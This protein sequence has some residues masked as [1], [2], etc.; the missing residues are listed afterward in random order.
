MCDVVIL[1]RIVLMYGPWWTIKNFW[2]EASFLWRLKF[3]LVQMVINLEILTGVS[4]WHGFVACGR[5]EKPCWLSSR[6]AFS[7]EFTHWHLVVLWATRIAD[8]H[9]VRNILTSLCCLYHADWYQWKV[10]NSEMPYSTFKLLCRLRTFLFTTLI[11]NT[12]NYWL[13]HFQRI[14]CSLSAA[15]E[16]SGRTGWKKRSLIALVF[17]PSPYEG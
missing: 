12:V 6:F 8:S 1:S 5:Y 11:V 15:T 13:I 9:T 16:S 17:L 3:A 7:R 14:D 2:E 4:H 10:A